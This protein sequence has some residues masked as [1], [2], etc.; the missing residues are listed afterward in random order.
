MEPELLVADEPI[1]ALDVSIRAQ[2]IN[3]LNRL[4]RD[5][6]LSYLFIAHDLSV[7]RFI[8]DRIAVIHRG[9]IVELARRKTFSCGPCTPIPGPCSPRCPYRT[10]K[11]SRKK[12]SSCM[13]RPCTSTARPSPYG[14]KRRRAITSWAARKKS[15]PGHPAKPHSVEGASPACRPVRLGTATPAPPP[16][17]CLAPSTHCLAPR[18][19]AYAG[20][21]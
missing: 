12:S 11:P 8:S 20:A 1:S 21:F 14:P 6:G 5:R 3:L 17:H 2:V 7:V 16:T 9:R 13:T 19:P 10:L 15:P 4:K 18:A